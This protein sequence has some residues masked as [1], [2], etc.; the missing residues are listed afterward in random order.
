MEVIITWKTVFLPKKFASGIFNDF[1]FSFLSRFINI[2][3]GTLHF[4]QNKPKAKLKTD[5]E[6][7]NTLL[8]W[9][10]HCIYQVSNTC[11]M[12]YNRQM[13]NLGIFSVL[14]IFCSTFTWK[15]CSRILK[16]ANKNYLNLYWTCKISTYYAQISLI[17]IKNFLS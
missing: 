7:R 10:W 8:S 4:L 12:T 2:H 17:C 11:D 3:N 6:N 14:C 5:K 1:L 13:S 9:S 16:I 15:N